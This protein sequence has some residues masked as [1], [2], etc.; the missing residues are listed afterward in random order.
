MDVIIEYKCQAAQLPLIHE[1]GG[2]KLVR[3]ELVGTL[4]VV[5]SRNLP[6]VIQFPGISLGRAQDTVSAR[7]GYRQGA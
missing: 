5:W 7:L 1:G 2:A 4:E 3:E 6:L